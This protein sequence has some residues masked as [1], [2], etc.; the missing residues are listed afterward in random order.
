MYREPRIKIQIDMKYIDA[1]ELI[2]EIERRESEIK[3]QIAE[4]GNFESNEIGLFNYLDLYDDILS[5]IGS[6]QQ[7]QLK[8]DLKEEITRFFSKNPIPYEHITD[9]PLLKNTAIH[10]YELGLNARKE[11]EK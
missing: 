10:F 8:V 1:E 11:D 5:F 7:E 3:S 6:L 4:L 2:A 9:W